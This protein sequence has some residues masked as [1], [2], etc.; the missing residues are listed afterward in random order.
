[1]NYEIKER[2]ER[3]SKLE[4]P[5]QIQK[6]LKII[7]ANLDYSESILKKR[8]VKFAFIG[9]AGIGKTS[10]ISK[11]T[12][13]IDSSGEPLLQVAS[14]KTTVCTVE[15][16]SAD[17][18]Y[19]EV[20]PVP[21]G[22]LMDY[23]DLYVDMYF[24]ES[25]SIKE[26]M[27]SSEQL[28]YIRKMASLESYPQKKADGSK[29]M[30]DK[31][32]KL[33]EKTNMT[34]SEFKEFV[35]SAIDPKS[36]T[37][38]VVEQEGL[39]HLERELKDVKKKR[40]VTLKDIEDLWIKKSFRM[41]NTGTNK[42][43]PMPQKITLYTDRLHDLK[44]GVG[45]V[46]SVSV[47]DTKG[48]DEIGVR[49]DID[50]L[51]DDGNTVC[52]FCTGFNDAPSESVRKV[53][54]R[55]VK[56][57]GKTKISKHSGI[58]VL[59]RYSESKNI[60]LDF[61]PTMDEFEIDDDIKIELGRSSRSDDINRALKYDSE[62]G[63]TPS[64]FFVDTH[65]E[66]REPLLDSALAMGAALLGSASDVFSEVAESLDKIEM[67]YK[68]ERSAKV[69]VKLNAILSERIRVLKIK[70]R[71]T[72]VHDVLIEAIGNPR[73]NSGSLAACN[74]R[75]GE[76]YCLDVYHELE[77]GLR[78]KAVKA[79]E[80]RIEKYLSDLM[81]L[82]K[83]DDFEPAH[84]YLD[85]LIKMVSFQKDN[86]WLELGDITSKVY[87]SELRDDLEFWEMV[88]SEWGRG[89]GYKKRV[90]S[91]YEGWVN[92]RVDKQVREVSDL[93]YRLWRTFVI[94]INGV[95]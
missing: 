18:T 48:L 34:K 20:D 5:S 29:G 63:L 49:K 53:I 39:E 64:V 35:I 52:F 13:L 79:F 86:F 93:T 25:S 69:F 37:K 10:A 90:L 24:P 94:T 26:S 82:R 9:A 33:I 41:V 74:R 58:M 44:E 59:E 7:Q 38:T 68:D 71:L 92:D 17:K 54:K 89:S 16:K 76:W 3:L 19:I 2:L 28:K 91:H 87:G 30:I 40:N 55:A 57:G 73:L 70:P 61:D 56:S 36:R 95:I 8:E 46:D 27:L 85:E 21:L 12:N 22:Q 6:Q 50:E 88:N 66:T 42:Q 65:R 14:G 45:D 4:L 83:R 80:K 62:I 15:I 67:F 47:F 23:I 75:Y 60:M 77:I 81:L 78:Q 84:D 31:A 1:M 51:I 32:S 43:I 11:L 72:S